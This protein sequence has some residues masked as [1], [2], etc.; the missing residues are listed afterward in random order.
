MCVYIFMDNTHRFVDNSSRQKRFGVSF[1]WGVPHISLHT[2]N[3]LHVCSQNV[4]TYVHTSTHI[5]TQMRTYVDTCV[6]EVVCSC[7]STTSS[8]YACLSVL[9]KHMSIYTYMH[10]LIYIYVCAC[11]CSCLLFIVIHVF[12]LLVY[13]LLFNCK[14]GTKVSD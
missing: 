7:M 1:L 2:Y 13:F 8:R 14:F 6:Y 11:T 5:H 10:I 3:C 12:Y 9:I 4:C